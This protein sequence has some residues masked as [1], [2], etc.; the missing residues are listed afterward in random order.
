MAGLVA[1]IG[2]YVIAAG[3]SLDTALWYFGDFKYHFPFSGFFSLFLLPVG[4]VL[5]LAS[6][7]VRLT[8]NFDARNRISL[9]GSKTAGFEVADTPGCDSIRPRRLPLRPRFSSL[10]SRG[11]ISCSL[12]VPLI[13]A[14]LQYVSLTSIG[15]RVYL[16]P[17]SQSSR[18]QPP[19]GTLTL[20]IDAK[21]RYYLDSRLISHE[22]LANSITRLVWPAAPVVY[23]DADPNLDY[24][25][26]VAAIDTIR[27]VHANVVLLTPPIKPHTR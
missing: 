17:V 19:T 16:L 24:Q 20:R 8:A 2:L 22:D 11:L 25:D 13:I 9:T 26:V 14:W 4:I 27:G 21:G 5:I 1:R 12:A 18:A 3:V 23:L 7:F 15:F 10:P 6:G